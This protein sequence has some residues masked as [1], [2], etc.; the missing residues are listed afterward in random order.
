MG[1]GT[2]PL[3]VDLQTLPLFV[4]ERWRGAPIDPKIDFERV[5]PWARAGTLLFWWVL[6]YYG[7]RVGRDLAGPWGGRLAVALL[8]C[9]PTL[10]AHASLATADLAVSA[11]LLAFLCHFREGRNAAGWVRRIGL[12][13]FWFGL[14]CLSKASG[15]VFAILCMWTTD[16]ERRLRMGEQD[17]Q[18]L[19]ASRGPVRKL[20]EL[21]FQRADSRERIQIVWLGMVLAFLLCGSDWLPDPEF[22]GWAHGLPDGPFARSMI[23]LSEHLR[24]FTNLGQGII[25][26]FGH[27]LRGHARF[28]LGDSGAEPLW[29]YY[30][31]LLTIKLSLPVLAL[32]AILALIR[33]RALVNWSCVA[34]LTLLA[35]S[36][37]CRVQIGI[38][39]F[40]P[41]VVLAIVG[42]AA[43]A[44][45]AIEGLRLEARSPLRS[46]FAAIAAPALTLAIGL[47]LAWTTTVSVA[48]WPDGL[49]YVNEA[50]GG[51]EQGYR[52]VSDSN[53][54]WGQGTRELA[55][56][57]R[58][59]GAGQ[60]D[61]WYFGTDPAIV[62]PDFRLLNPLNFP[63]EESGAILERVQGHQV[64]VST[65]MLYG[66]YEGSRPDWVSFFRAQQPVDRTSTFLIYDFRAPAVAPDRVISQSGEARSPSGT[67]R[68]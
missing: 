29:Y 68:E 2:M 10:L 34:A 56:W 23:W 21:A 43:A 46:R 38:R 47:G 65:S 6:L 62:V 12:P 1:L 14:V 54:D 25:R 58:D 17:G 18:G 51:Q 13:A 26:Q 63:V 52:L 36:L 60:L 7:R 20:W 9:E 53:Y 59:H 16:L 31:V 30:P 11:C 40:L 24:I 49:R 57:R 42:L 64:A 19:A 48:S 67:S 27:N 3:P 45:Q 5:L 37:C 55:R 41:L 39:L 61:V 8:A 15:P 66:A 4:W 32:P 33:R 28:L 35:F 22:V 44:V 50:W